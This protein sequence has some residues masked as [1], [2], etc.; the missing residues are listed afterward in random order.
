[1]NT[2]NG[3]SGGSSS[4]P[5]PSIKN[6]PLVG[7]AWTDLYRST[8]IHETVYELLTQQYE[9]ARIQEARE[10]P[11]VKVLDQAAVPEERHPA[12]AVVAIVGT[13]I[14]VFLA[15]LGLLLQRWGASWDVDDPRRLL[16]ARFSRTRR[17]NA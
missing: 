4:S 17:G 5:Y 7:V 11:T 13:L 3:S 8:K 10:L 2:G 12:I 1:L 14:S 9:V 15:C 16:L 6:L